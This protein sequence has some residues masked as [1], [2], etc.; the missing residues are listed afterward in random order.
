M[1]WGYQGKIKA[2]K[3]KTKNTYKLSRQTQNKAKQGKNQGNL[4]P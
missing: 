3:D 4:T 2:F 1:V